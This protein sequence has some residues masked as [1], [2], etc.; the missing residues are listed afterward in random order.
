MV[1]HNKLLN[2]TTIV[3]SESTNVDYSK[4]NILGLVDLFSLKSLPL[5]SKTV[6]ELNN[7]SN[8]N[9][10][11]I[12]ILSATKPEQIKLHEKITRLYSTQ[13]RQKM[14]AKKG[15]IIV[16]AEIS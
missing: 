10:E 13:Q 7:T 4:K 5:T 11:E 6:A 15:K 12:N 2:W 8:H 14:T 16:F 9:N 3:N 1:R